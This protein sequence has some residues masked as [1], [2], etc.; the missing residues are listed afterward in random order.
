[1][2]FELVLSPFFVTL[3][4]ILLYLFISTALSLASSTK[5]SSCRGSHGK[6]LCRKCLFCLGLGG[7]C[8]SA[9]NWSVGLSWVPSLMMVY[10]LQS[11]VWLNKVF[12]CHQ[13]SPSGG[14]LPD[15]SSLSSNSL[16]LAN[17]G[18]NLFLCLSF[19][20]ADSFFILVK[21][22]SVNHS[23]ISC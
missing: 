1:V 8:W 15:G 2:T 6:L 5:G 3:R 11:S 23:S 21:G 7:M 13:V 9:M 4:G 19:S 22:L 10:S 17:G 20:N 16:A 18:G 12:L 14:V